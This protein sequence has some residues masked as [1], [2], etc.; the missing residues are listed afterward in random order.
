[1]SIKKKKKRP[2]KILP[3]TEK[4]IHLLSFKNPA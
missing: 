1:M 2:G 3:P 4:A